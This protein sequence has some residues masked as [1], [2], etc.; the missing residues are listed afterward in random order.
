MGRPRQVAYGGARALS[1]GV[2]LRQ[3]PLEMKRRSPER[4]PH[5]LNVDFSAH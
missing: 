3:A 4:K 5:V 1:I 2:G